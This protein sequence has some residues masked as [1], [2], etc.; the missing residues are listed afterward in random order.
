M[1]GQIN[2]LSALRGGLNVE[3]PAKKTTGEVLFLDHLKDALEYTDRLQNEADQ[4]A[5]NLL[6]GDLENLHQLMIATEQAQ[7]SL[8]LTVQVVNKVI[9]AYQEIY[10]MQV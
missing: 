9:Q 8:Q 3:G 7:L 1:T 6:S 4:A 10:R 5:Q 2:P